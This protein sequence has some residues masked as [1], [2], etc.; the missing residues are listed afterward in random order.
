MSAR[1]ERHVVQTAASAIDET[2]WPG[3]TI[4]NAQMNSDLLTDDL[5]NERAGNERFWLIGQ[6]DVAIGRVTEGDDKGRFRVSVPG[7]DYYNT[8]T[9]NVDSGG[10]NRIALRMLDPD[11][12]GRGLFPR[13]VFFRTAGARDGWARLARNLEAE[14]DKDLIEANRGTVCWPFES[15][16]YER[17]EVKTV[18]DRGVESLKVLEPI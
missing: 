5:K 3:V 12:D 16:Q 13:Q 1:N 2:H 17:A 10:A 18:D 4:H 11:H 9:G 8:R 7:F 15:G 14:V 6:P